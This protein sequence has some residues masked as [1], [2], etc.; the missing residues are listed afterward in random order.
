LKN[1]TTRAHRAQRFPLVKT[2]TPILTTTINPAVETR[3]N[4][5][6][7]DPTGG[8]GL[9]NNACDRTVFFLAP[10][11]GIDR[12]SRK[13]LERQFRTNIQSRGAF[14]SIEFELSPAAGGD[15]GLPEDFRPSLLRWAL[16]HSGAVIIAV[17]DTPEGAEPSSILHPVQTVIRCS[18]ANVHIWSDYLGRRVRPRQR[19]A[20]VRLD[21]VGVRA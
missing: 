2:P 7:S 1:D 20:V 8:F 5:R 11:Q 19:F 17:A 3:D 13:S 18:E 14:A 12:N 21:A 16:K 9:V 15:E 6:R 4:L 10:G